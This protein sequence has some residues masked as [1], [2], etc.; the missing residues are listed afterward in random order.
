MRYLIVAISVICFFSMDEQSLYYSEGRID[1]EEILVQT[2]NI[3]LN[4]K[5]DIIKESFQKWMEDKYDVDLDGKSLLFFDKE[6]MKANGVVIPEISSRKID[7]I[8][9]VDETA[10]DATSFHV[11][12]KFKNGDFIIKK[13]FPYE[14]KELESIVFQYITAYLSEFYITGAKAVEKTIEDLKDHKG[15]I[16]ELK[17]N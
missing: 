15:D 5:P 13:L 6:F 7:L 2:I 12:A 9:K 4:G 10:A 8:V 1:Y 3:K 16:K 17:K 11:F 14:F